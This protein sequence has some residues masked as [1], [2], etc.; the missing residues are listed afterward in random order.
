MRSMR[1]LFHRPVEGYRHRYEMHC[2]NNWCSAC[3]HNAPQEI[4]QAYYSA[5]YAGMVVTDHFLL[6]SSAVDRRLP[7][8]EKMEAY[9]AA[10]QAAKDWAAKQARDFVVLF[11][12]EHHYGAG[13][14]VLTYGI[15]LEFLLAHPDLHLLPLPAYA[16][17]VR[18]GGGWIAMA[19][20]FREEPY[21]DPTIQPQ[22]ACLDGA[23]AFN[24]GN[25]TD[26]ENQRAVAFIR[27]H[28][29]VPT[30]GGDVHSI[31][32]PGL[33]QAGIALRQ[34]ARSSQDLVQALREGNYC[35]LI[36]GE[37]VLPDE[38]LAGTP[39]LWADHR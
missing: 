16:A 3:A 19:H 35:L 12:L 36:R 34:R 26:R 14:E 28:H 25:R 33:G 17:A 11:G 20:P 22:P 7:W 37:W 8:K 38:V 30:S 23:E 29:I 9:W 10:Y 1:E 21:I 32:D 31:A 6:G 4:A 15:D 39:K 27:Q 2:H 13:K 18:Q 5:G 24:Y